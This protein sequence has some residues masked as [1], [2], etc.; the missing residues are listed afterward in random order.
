MLRL[1]VKHIGV[2]VLTSC[3]LSV[4]L[5]SACGLM[6]CLRSR[7]CLAV[8]DHMSASSTAIS[9]FLWLVNDFGRM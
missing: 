1:V 4:M 8:V 9:N 2:L 3:W 6:L 7:S 5:S